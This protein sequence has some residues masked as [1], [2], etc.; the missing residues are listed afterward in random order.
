MYSVFSEDRE[1]DL[2]R[3]AVIFRS[4]PI[5]LVSQHI[6]FLQSP[7]FFLLA[8]FFAVEETYFG[9]RLTVT[10]DFIIARVSTYFLTY[11]LP[12]LI[13]HSLT[14]LLHGAEFFLRS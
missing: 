10:T 11:S 9:L 8:F 7:F 2:R 13:T 3:Y 6:L 5:R 1:N 14:C 12:Y 4:A